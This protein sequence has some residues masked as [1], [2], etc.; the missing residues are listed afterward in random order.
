MPRTIPRERCLPVSLPSSKEGLHGFVCLE[1]PWGE[2]RGY[3]R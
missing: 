1:L 3:P 2:A